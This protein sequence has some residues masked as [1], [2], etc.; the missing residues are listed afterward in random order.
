MQRRLV[1][2]AGFVFGSLFG[3]AALLFVGYTALIAQTGGIVGFFG[4][5]V[6]LLAF[7]GSF[8]APYALVRFFGKGRESLAG[9]QLV[10]FGAHVLTGAF[11]VVVTG[12]FVAE[13]FGQNTAIGVMVT[14]DGVFG[15]VWGGIFGTMFTRRWSR[16]RQ[17]T[18]AT[19]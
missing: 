13:P 17:Q 18:T 3:G 19:A 16:R 2:V 11:L 10:R 15:F 5:F 4:Y 6:S 8:A 7:M 1:S 14:L 12:M 9:T